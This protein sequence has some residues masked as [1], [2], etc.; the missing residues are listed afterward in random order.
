VTFFQDAGARRS[1]ASDVAAIPMLS[2]ED[3]AAAAEWLK[4]AFGFREEERYADDD[5]RVTHVTLT[6]GN[7]VVM[8]G[9]PG[10]DYRSPRRH[11]ETCEAAARWLDVPY[12]VDGVFVSVDDI[13]AHCERARRAGARILSEPDEA[14]GARR[15]RVEDLEG[16]RW[17]FVQATG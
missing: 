10:P 15:Y 14:H 17:M 8:I 5:G 13:E 3:C 12:V 7:G 2:Y 6:H 9:W 1:Y 16:H 11:A 4:T